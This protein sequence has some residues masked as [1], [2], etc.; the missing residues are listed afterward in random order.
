M[1]DEMYYLVLFNSDAKY[2]LVLFISVSLVSTL[3]HTRYFAE[4]FMVT[5]SCIPFTPKHLPALLLHH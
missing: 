2:S 1:S 4:L 5:G 3:S